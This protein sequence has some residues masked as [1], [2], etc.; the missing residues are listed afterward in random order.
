MVASSEAKEG[1]R[2]GRRAPMTRG[3]EKHA[4]DLGR[5]RDDG[6]RQQRPTASE[7]HAEKEMRETRNASNAAVS[8]SEAKEGRRRGRRAPATRE[9][10]RRAGDMGRRRD[11]ERRKRGPTAPKA[12][13]ETETRE[14]RDTSNAIVATSNSRGRS[15]CAGGARRQHAS[16]RDAREIWDAAVTTSDASEDRRRLRHTPRW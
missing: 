4:S 13:A 6:R 11:D 15:D 1:R 3:R 10:E 12:H 2:R 8:T 5:R 16:A 9:R 14:P 7:A